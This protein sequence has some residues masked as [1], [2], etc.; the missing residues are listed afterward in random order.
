LEPVFQ[1][2]YQLS[3]PG[4]GII[5]FP[6]R[7]RMPNN[8]VRDSPSRSTSYNELKIYVRLTLGKGTLI[9]I[10]SRL[11]WL[12]PLHPEAITGGSRPSRDGWR[13]S[14]Y[15]S[16]RQNELYSHIRLCRLAGTV[17]QRKSPLPTPLLAVIQEFCT[18]LILR[19]GNTS[20][21]NASS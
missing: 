5:P 1:S 13:R 14:C 19:L 7:T 20:G 2:L 9:R 15:L 16:D 18:G 8:H 6:S 11:M 3:Y 17:I 21:L 12:L 4:S 10:L